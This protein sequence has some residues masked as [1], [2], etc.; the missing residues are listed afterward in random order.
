MKHR[1]EVIPIYI[2]L[3]HFITRYRKFTSL[4]HQVLSATQLAVKTFTPG[5]SSPRGIDPFDQRLQAIVAKG[6]RLDSMDFT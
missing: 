4:K 3:Q 1:I 6:M 5:V 2:H